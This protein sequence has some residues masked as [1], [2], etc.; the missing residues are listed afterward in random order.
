MHLITNKSTFYIKLQ[1]AE[2]GYQHFLLSKTTK[3]GVNIIDNMTVH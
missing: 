1:E 3:D 2:T